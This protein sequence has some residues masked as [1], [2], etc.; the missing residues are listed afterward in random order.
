MIELRLA[1]IL[2]ERGRSVYWLWKQTGVRY[3][4]IWDMVNGHITRLNLEIL[5][6]ICDVL[7]CQPGD[8]IVKVRR[9][10]KS[11]KGR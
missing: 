1:A 11:R 7:E 8:L 5:D 6:R 4:T 2:D 3:A 10:T 9:P